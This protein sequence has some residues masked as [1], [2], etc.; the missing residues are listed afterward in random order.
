V[1]LR[2][3]LG[4]AEAGELSFAI[5]GDSQEF[6][7]TVSSQAPDRNS[8]TLA[9]DQRV[10]TLSAGGLLQWSRRL[11]DHRLGL[12]GDVRWVEGETIEKVYSNGA[13]L[14]RR[15]AGGQQVIAHVRPRAARRRPARL[16]DDLRR[17]A[18]GDPARAQ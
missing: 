10:P 16:L 6:R 18:P 14:R 2:G 13:F 1:S 3:R 4:N 9:L 7:S 15:I 5:F 8:E 17:R 12:G 11:G